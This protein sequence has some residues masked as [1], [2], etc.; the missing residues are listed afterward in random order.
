MT[1]QVYDGCKLMMTK[2]NIFILPYLQELEF[3]PIL[4]VIIAAIDSKLKANLA[5]SCSK[6]I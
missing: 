1:F 4:K 2:T 6:A 3:V 5:F